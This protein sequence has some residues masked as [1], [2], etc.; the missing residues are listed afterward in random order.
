M[1][2]EGL[3]VVAGARRRGDGRAE[4]VEIAR[5]APRRRA[6]PRRAPRRA[7]NA[8]ASATSARAAPGLRSSGDERRIARRRAH[9]EVA[10]VAAATALDQT[11]GLELAQ[12]LLHRRAPDAEGARQLALGRQGVAAGDQPQADVA[13]D[14]LGHDLVRPR[15]V[16]ALE[17]TLR[18]SIG[19][20]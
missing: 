18:T 15:R 5:I 6:P 9:H 14:L 7:R 10:A 16:E 1:A 4:P 12:C 11:V 3:V 2:H 8:S 13:S 19:Q 20:A 17:R